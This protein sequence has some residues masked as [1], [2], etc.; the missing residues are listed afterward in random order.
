MKIPDQIRLA[1][2]IAIRSEIYICDY[3]S[4]SKYQII[5]THLSS[6]IFIVQP[7]LN[8]TSPL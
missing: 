6:Q 4:K 7:K 5:S 3:T 1:S 2:P 8:T